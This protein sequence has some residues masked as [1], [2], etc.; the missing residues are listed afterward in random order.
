MPESAHGASRV[1]VELRD[2][3]PMPHEIGNRTYIVAD[4]EPARRRRRPHRRRSAS[5]LWVVALRRAAAVLRTARATTATAGGCGPALAGFGLGLIGWD[6]CRRRKRAPRAARHAQTSEPERP[7]SERLEVVAATSVSRT[8]SG[9]GSGSCSL[10]QLDLG[11]GAAAVVE[12]D[13]PAVVVGV[14]VGAHAEHLG[15]RAGEPDQEAAG[16]AAAR[17]PTGR[18]VTSGPLSPSYQ[19]WAARS[20]PSSESVRTRPR[21]RSLATVRIWVLVVGVERVVAEGVRRDQARVV[22]VDRQQVAGRRGRRA[23]C[24]SR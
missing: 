21:P 20:R 12:G 1:P 3:Q 13:H 19:R 9:S 2:D 11:V 23:G 4:V 8:G 22:V 10:G 24:R 16:R 14:A 5:A 6:Y 15:E 18:A 7:G 17:G